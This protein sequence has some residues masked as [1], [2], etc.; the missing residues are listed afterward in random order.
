MQGQTGRDLARNFVEEVAARLRNWNERDDRHIQ[1]LFGGRDIAVEATRLTGCQI[2]HVLPYHG[3]RSHEFEDPDRLLTNE[4]YGCAAWWRQFGEAIGETYGGLPA[5]LAGE[6]LADMTA[7]PLLNY[8]LALRYRK[9]GLDAW[10]AGNLNLIYRD[11][12]DDVYDRRWGAGEHPTAGVL[13]KQDFHAL[14][15]ELGLAAWH[16]ASRTVSESAVEAACERAGLKEQLMPLKDAAR[17]GAISLLAAFYFRQAGHIP[18]GERTFEFTHK[19]FG[20]YL[21][22]RRLVRAIG[23]IHDDRADKTRRRRPWSEEAA[24]IEWCRMTGPAPLDVYLLEFMGR[25]TG[26]ERE[27]SQDGLVTLDRWRQTFAD[28][29]TYELHNGLPMHA[30]GLSNFHDMTRQARNAEEALLAAHLCCASA[31]ETAS[32]I[33]WPNCRAIHDLLDR[34]KQGRTWSLSSLCL[35]WFQREEIEDDERSDGIFKLSGE[36]SW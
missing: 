20:E 6:N 29:L 5:S 28:L 11:L 36:I 9:G 19:S 18:G 13:A 14:L 12:L 2:L 27:E 24:L 8:L 31:S 4:T 22:A 21:T 17:Q 35:G 15:D 7:Q 32:V 30:L 23:E 1:V 10:T 26:V 34:L 3:I 33:D 25:E 16:G